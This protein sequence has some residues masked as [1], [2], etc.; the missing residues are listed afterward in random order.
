METMPF[1]HDKII[2]RLKLFNYKY[3]LN[4]QI[5]KIF[6]PM[7]CYLKIDFAAGRVKMTSHLSFG[8][9]SLALEYNFLLYGLGLYVLAWYYWTILNKATFLLFG[10]FLVHFVICFIKIE[11]LKVSIHNWIESDNK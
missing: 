7:F 2:S 9:R 1:N 11:S 6:L 5:L 10:I 3:E 4:G 8:I